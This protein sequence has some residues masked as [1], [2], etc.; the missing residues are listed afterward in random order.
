MTVVSIS[1]QAL[2]HSA[3]RLRN[4]GEALKRGFISYAERRSR[5]DR[6]N[7][8]NAMTDAEL[9]TL[10]VK[11]DRIVHHVYRDLFYI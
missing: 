4:F 7:H 8:L 9:A 11:R 5:L 6:I 3:S 1:N 10:G 2:S